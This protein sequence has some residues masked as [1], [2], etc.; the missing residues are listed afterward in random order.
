MNEV[1]VITDIL[2]QVLQRQSQDILNALHLVRS[3]KILLR[4]LRQDGWGK[5]FNTLVSFCERQGID[6]PDMIARYM[7]GTGRSCQQQDHVTVDHYYHVD[8]FI[9]VID[10]QLM[11]LASTERAFPATKLVKSSLR[12]KMDDEFLENCM[13]VYIERE[14]ADTID[15]D[16]VIDA[17]PSLKTRKSKFK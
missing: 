4:E 6:T 1:M 12:N 2:C 14:L 9:V 13:V 7:E 15:S 5:F 16:S 17:F 3:T 11:E 8:V 10:F